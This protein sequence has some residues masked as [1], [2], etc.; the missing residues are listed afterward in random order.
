MELQRHRGVIR[1][2]LGY[3]AVAMGLVALYI[4]IAPR[5]FYDDFP[6]GGS[7]WVSVLPPYN[8]HLIRDYGAAGL[9][10]ASLAAM[11]AFWMDRR[12]VQAT[13]VAVFIGT[14][15]HAIYHFTTTESLSTADN[16]GSLG[17][18]TLQAVLPLALLFLASGRRQDPEA[19]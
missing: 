2:A 17:A 15:P 4:L 3:L 13:C 9:G 8:E 16:V 10:L 7:E 12:L 18:L 19:A 1:F 6:V 14:A 5:S 11:A